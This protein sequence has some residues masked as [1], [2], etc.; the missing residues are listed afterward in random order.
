MKKKI[1]L[2]VL[3]I[4]TFSL[5][6][7]SSI[8]I[9]IWN[10][11]YIEQMKSNLSIDNKL[12][13]NSIKDKTREETLIWLKESVDESH[14]RVTYIDEKGEVIIDTLKDEEYMDNHNLR[15]EVSDA[16]R[17]GEGYS[18][19]YSNTL[20]KNMIYNALLLEDGSILRVSMG[21][22]SMK[23]VQQRYLKY[24]ILTLILVMAVSV[25][26][27]SKFSHFIV[28]PIEELQFLTSKVASGD[29]HK[30]VNILTN[31]EIGKLGRTFNDMADKLESTIKEAV[32]R[33][34][35]LEAILKSMDSG[36]IAVDENYNVII[37]N[38]YAKKIFGIR[39]NIIGE[40]LMEHIRD[41]ELENVFKER[42]DEYK[43]INILWP[44]EKELRIKTGD[45]ISDGKLIGTVAVVQDITDLKKLENMRT[46]F[47]ANVSHELKTPLTSIRGFAET[48]RYVDDDE[49]KDRFLNIINEEAERLTRLI[50]D[51]LILS[52][53]EQ[54]KDEKSSDIN[55]EYKIN[56]IYYL[57]KSVAENKDISI[58][59]NL[60]SGI[61][62]YGNEDRFTQ[63]M[64]N[65]IDN[66]IK[67]S[68]KGSSVYISSKTYK[69]DCIII[70]EDTGV[71]IQKE[72]IY[73]L[74]ERFYRVDKARSRANGGTGLGLAIVKHIVL[75]FGGNIDVK[76]EVSKGSKFIITLPIKKGL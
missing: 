64:I 66:A 38:P 29:L 50:E 67:Y 58:T 37:I 1:M 59:L 4:I 62:L 28:R 69:K 12:I 3:G 68:D 51:I 21:V 13:A 8:F 55:V 20:D 48:L 60:E 61:V 41:F 52:D 65:L 18:V 47:V 40:N 7:V 27:S 36:V 46:Q 31:D 32:D 6:L 63:M 2:F 19:R 22:D 35:K 17:N 25:L 24:Y 72:H 76:S 39:K 56:D 43:E 71:G 54:H 70:V 9:I 45:I 75:G 5:I 74:F 10:Y 44:S 33:Q 14:I 34:D 26:L 42:K 30:R 23:S 11:Q 53:I 16:I 57:M 49:K 73:R 15:K